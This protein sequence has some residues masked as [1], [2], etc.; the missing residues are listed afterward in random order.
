MGKRPPKIENAE[1]RE[2]LNAK[3]KGVVKRAVIEIALEDDRTF[4]NA[5]EHLLEESPRVK[6]KL[7]QFA[8]V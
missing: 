3:T 1:P 6:R 7:R 4:S 2:P 5:V 8:A